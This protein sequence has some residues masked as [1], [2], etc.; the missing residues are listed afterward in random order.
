VVFAVT[1]VYNILLNFIVYY[2]YVRVLLRFPLLGDLACVVFPTLYATLQFLVIFSPFGD[3]FSY[4]YTQIDWG[5]LMRFVSLFGLSGVTF[6]IT[7]FSSIIHYHYIQWRAR[8]EEESSNRS[9]KYKMTIGFIVIFIL[10]LTYG[11][12][13]RSSYRGAFYQTPIT[14]TI[15][16][17]IQ[18][19]CLMDQNIYSNLTDVLNRTVNLARNHRLVLWS[20]TAVNISSTNENDLIS[21]VSDIASTYGTFIGMTYLLQL[22][23]DSPN[24]QNIL[25][26]ISDNGDVL[27]KYQK[28]HPVPFVESAVQPGP[29][30]LE[31]VTTS[32]GR[33]SGAIC[34]DLNY[35][36]NLLQAGRDEVD[37]L[38]QPSWTWGPI[39]LWHSE[40]NAMR[41][42][43][44]GFT[45]FRCSSN[46]YSG[47]YTP[48]GASLYS[49]PM[50][51]Q[52]DLEGISIPIT[53]RVWTWYGLFG[54][55]MAW[56]SL[57]LSV[58]FYLPLAYIPLRFIQKFLTH[59]PNV[60]FFQKFSP[61][62]D[63]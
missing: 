6:V 45:L 26:F 15:D 47:V 40:N 5:N 42:V 44:L 16:P 4:A 56:I 35:P 58:F 36:W 12:F 18:A 23:G 60:G 1:L 61:L 55:I 14:K 10:V 48:N 24:Q 59:F 27:F 39:G 29:G 30:Y 62:K 8:A 51:I 49:H 3:I 17:T 38:L 50:L 63:E 33:V 41:A 22:P 46:G 54:D 37:L 7:F 11:G 52:G 25:V 2:S 31:I 20:E 13:A 34:F 32:L 53:K 19:A 21:N 43:E 57:V 9:K 28:S